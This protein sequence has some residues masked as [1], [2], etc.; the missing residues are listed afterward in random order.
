MIQIPG[1]TR[2][3]GMATPEAP[4]FDAPT[5]GG[6]IGEQHRAK[7][8]AAQRRKAARLSTEAGRGDQGAGEHPGPAIA[9][10]LDLPHQNTRTWCDSQQPPL[11]GQGLRTGLYPDLDGEAAGTGPDDPPCQR[12]IIAQPP[13]QAATGTRHR[14][15]AQRAP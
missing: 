2:K 10:Q 12:A 8:T 1:R 14:A 13:R 5:L 7:G 3:Q 15:T 9:S 4:D 6:R 11:A